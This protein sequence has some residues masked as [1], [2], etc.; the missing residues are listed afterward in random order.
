MSKFSANLLTCQSTQWAL[1]ELYSAWSMTKAPIVKVVSKC[2]DKGI[3]R[4]SFLQIW[5]RRKSAGQ[6]APHICKPGATREVESIQLPSGRRCRKSG[7]T[8]LLQTLGQSL[9][10][11]ACP[12]GNNYI[13]KAFFIQRG[14]FIYMR[15]AGCKGH[16]EGCEACSFCARFAACLSL[17]P[18]WSARRLASSQSQTCQNPLCG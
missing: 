7:G 1:N 4:K 12:R 13:H 2:G 17:S 8:D 15:N 11:R 9:S 16:P 5:P 14:S 10:A 3:I 6:Q 18:L